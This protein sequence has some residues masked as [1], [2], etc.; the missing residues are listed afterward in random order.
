MIGGGHCF[1]RTRHNRAGLYAFGVIM[2]I[3]RLHCMSL[4][5]DEWL[6]GCSSLTNPIIPVAVVAPVTAS[7][8]HAARPRTRFRDRRLTL[9][10]ADCAGFTILITG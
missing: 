5:I 9:T 8:P 6:A 3:H 7:V 2:S 10:L 4:A 1:A